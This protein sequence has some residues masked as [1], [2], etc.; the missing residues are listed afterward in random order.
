MMTVV[1]AVMNWI[2]FGR[3][4]TISLDVPVVDVFQLIGFVMVIMTVET[5]V[6][7]ANQIAPKKVGIFYTFPS[8]HLYLKYLLYIHS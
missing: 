6:M 8:T 4:L 7:K 3:V 5:S 2:V 1:M